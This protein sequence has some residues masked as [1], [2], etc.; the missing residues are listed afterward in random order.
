MSNKKIKNKRFKNKILSDDVLSMSKKTDMKEKASINKP[1]KSNKKNIDVYE[2]V[3]DKANV[4]NRKESNN[5]TKLN[6]SSKKGSSHKPVNTSKA[7]SKSSSKQAVK[8]K[9][10]VLKTKDAVKKNK[11]KQVKKTI[12]IPKVKATTKKSSKIT[13]KD[14]SK[15]KEAKQPLNSASQSG[16]TVEFKKPGFKL[17]EFQHDHVLD[18]S[19]SKITNQSN[20][21][22][23]KITNSSKTGDDESSSVTDSVSDWSSFYLESSNSF[24]RSWFKL[25]KY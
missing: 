16:D 19:K 1:L 4:R 14:F 6:S 20:K 9:V 18:V 15:T 25:F 23:V 5:K 12:T 21:Q 10:S 3:F 8:Q 13:Q 17:V 24:L 22:S 7:Q 11:T 2:L